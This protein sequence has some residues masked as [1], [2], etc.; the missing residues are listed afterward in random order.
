VVERAA[1]N[2][3]Q[4]QKQLLDVSRHADTASGKAAPARGSETV[5]PCSSET[6]S[7]PLIQLL[8]KVRPSFRLGAAAVL[9]PTLNAGSADESLAR[10]LVL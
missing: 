2:T 7:M 8:P 4:Q 5:A 3:I 1:T 6:I 10:G 9:C